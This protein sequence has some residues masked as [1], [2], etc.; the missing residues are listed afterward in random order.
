[1]DTEEQDI[2]A[3]FKNKKKRK[4]KK[5]VE[6]VITKETHFEDKDDEEL[7]YE[8]MLARLYAQMEPNSAS[9]RV[10][11]QPPK[12]S[13]IGSKR[14]GWGNFETTAESLKRDPN[15]LSTFVE[16]E[17]GTTVSHAKDGVLV[18]KGRFRTNQMESILKKYVER[19][20]K[21]KTCQSSNTTLVRNQVTRLTSQQCLDCRS[22]WTVENI[23]KA[24]H[25]AKKDDNK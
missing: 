19:Y 20:V 15:H 18:I 17:L 12:L 24:Y 1:M 22:E 23:Q 9:K 10:R 5:V 25:V 13:L 21:C 8:D 6:E 4:E 2:A 14:T 16:N 3:L 11:L 7:S